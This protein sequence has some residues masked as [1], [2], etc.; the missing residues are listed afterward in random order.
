MSPVTR[1]G[2]VEII[3]P[4]PV[5][6]LVSGP[7]MDCLEYMLSQGVAF[8]PFSGVLRER[9]S[10]KGG[11][12]WDSWITAGDVVTVYGGKVKVSHGGDE[13]YQKVVSG[14]P[15][16][17]V[18]GIYQ[19]SSGNALNLEEVIS[20]FLRMEAIQDS[21]RF[22][23]A[24][25]H[26]A[27]V[28]SD[29]KRELATEMS[30]NGLLRAAAGDNGWILR[31]YANAALTLLFEKG[32]TIMMPPHLIDASDLNMGDGLYLMLC[33]AIT[34]SGRVT[35]CRLDDGAHHAFALREYR[36]DAK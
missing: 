7:P 25:R 14:K 27:G 21:P 20:S 6:A 32:T 5:P 30:E 8:M 11:F 18:E 22:V 34:D 13:V 1:V 3:T 33:N 23:S 28:L 31:Q 17:D 2:N 36:A 29:Y 26:D 16:L 15:G 19:L 4:L 12:F 24:S 9:V 35:I 10:D